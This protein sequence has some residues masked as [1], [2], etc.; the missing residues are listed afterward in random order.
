MATQP[1]ESSRLLRR[2]GW[3]LLLGRAALVTLALTWLQAGGAAGWAWGAPLPGSATANASEPT[4]SPAQAQE[5]QPR[6][7]RQQRD[8]W[9]QSDWLLLRERL[10]QRNQALKERL[11]QSR[12]CLQAADSSAALERCRQSDRW[13]YGM[14][15]HGTD[16]RGGP[17]QGC[18]LW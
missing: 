18:P 2:S 3:P 11:E 1:L 4:P 17:W 6:E 14:P 12:R 16:G 8:Q 7:E 13:S 15:M 10:L 5:W 9:V